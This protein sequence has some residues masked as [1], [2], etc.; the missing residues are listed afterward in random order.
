MRT[1]ITTKYSDCRAF[2]ESYP[3]FIEAFERDEEASL[4]IEL[5]EWDSDR[6]F[7]HAFICED[8]GHE[9]YV[10]WRDRYVG[11][12]YTDYVKS[13]K[14][15]N[16]S[17]REIG[18]SKIELRFKACE[19]KYKKYA[20]T[21]DGN[22]SKISREFEA[23]CKSDKT[24]CPVC[25]AVW[26]RSPQTYATT[27]VDSI[28]M[29][30]PLRKDHSDEAHQQVIDDLFRKIHEERQKANK[31]KA[32]ERVAALEASM[33]VLGLG[34][35]NT[36]TT[37]LDSPKELMR[38]ISKILTLETNIVSLKKWLEALYQQEADAVKAVKERS[39]LMQKEP[40]G[41]LK[42]LQEQLE[43]L[44]RTDPAAK[45]KC[46]VVTKRIA[47]SPAFPEEPVYEKP[48]LFNKKKVE[49][50]N[51]QKRQSFELAKMEYQR[52][53]EECMHQQK[54]YDEEYDEQQKQAREEYIRAC[55]EAHAKRSAEILKLEA[56]IAKCKQEL[57][58]C[59]DPARI[60][61]T[62]EKALKDMIDANIANAEDLL[63]RTYD[64]CKQLY[65]CNIIF[66]KYR[67]PVALA[68]FYEYLMSGR[69]TTLAGADGAYN[70]YEAE[71]RANLIIFQLS[72]VIKNLEKIRENQFTIYSQLSDMN[73]TLHQLNRTMG[74]AVDELRGIKKNTGAISENT[75]VIAH[76]TAT[77]AYYAKKSAELTDALGYM[78][79][80]K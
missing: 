61:T 52:A 25:G 75:A 50:E 68:T 7:A 10:D 59:S 48:G 11:F 58:R 60:A 32:E 69:C 24:R 65:G 41:K 16:Q 39:F 47:P 42:E 74:S 40:A 54:L 4:L 20:C 77:T 63:R 28:F 18:T 51:N 19:K 6:V 3:R 2:E 56:E 73:Q 34:G 80:L 13:Q 70:L 8:C 62:P 37:S 23:F 1:H 9:Y 71:I 67:N 43:K 29:A 76:N 55:E 12:Y 5:G 45:L 14:P 57:E 30:K 79:A 15:K 35:I 49:A 27:Q 38:Y 53:L 22:Y 46:K 21:K 66:G 36:E 72:E 78:V 33:N 31:K 44:K 64:A 26:K 17:V